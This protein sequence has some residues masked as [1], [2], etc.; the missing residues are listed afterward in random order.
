MGDAE[1]TSYQALAMNSSNDQLYRQLERLGDMMGDGEHLEPGGDW[2]SKE[3]RQILKALG[4]I[5]NPPR[6]VAGINR[7]MAQLIDKTPCP[8]CS[9]KLQQ[10]R[11]GSS[12]LVCVGCGSKFKTKRV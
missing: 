9:Q 8:K 6:D 12:R 2:I 1:I 10:T 3:Y 4:M 7:R 5:K 11:S